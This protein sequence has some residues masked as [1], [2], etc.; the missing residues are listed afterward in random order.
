MAKKKKLSTFK[1]V[2]VKEIIS[3]LNDDNFIDSSTDH[4]TLYK[5]I[6]INNNSKLFRH[7]GKFDFFNTTYNNTESVLVFCNISFPME[8]K[9]S[10]DVNEGIVNLIDFLEKVFVQLD[11]VEIMKHNDYNTNTHIILIKTI[12][13]K[14]KDDVCNSIITTFH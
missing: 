2:R 3:E 6:F 7:I 5:Q 8:K 14:S 10:I 13:N 9:D 11:S 12:I 4:L 1:M